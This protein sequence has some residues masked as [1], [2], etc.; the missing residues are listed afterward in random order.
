MK[1][2][3]K[4]ILLIGVSE[5]N[6]YNSSPSASKNKKKKDKRLK[7]KTTSTHTD[8]LFLNTHTCSRRPILLT[9]SS[10]QA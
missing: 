6:S 5:H 9:T 10:S 1:L 3:L 8:L 4:P 7:L 2:K